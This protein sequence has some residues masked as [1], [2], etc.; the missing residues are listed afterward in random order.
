M[1]CCTDDICYDGKDAETQ[2]AA[3]TNFTVEVNLDVPEKEN[4][5]RSY[6]I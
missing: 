4:R 5:D 3:E 1:A 2:E 6:S